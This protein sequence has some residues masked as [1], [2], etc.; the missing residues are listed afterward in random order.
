MIQLGRLYRILQGPKSSLAGKLREL[1]WFVSDG[2]LSCQVNAGALGEMVL[3]RMV[4]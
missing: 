4:L 2:T 3:T 1:V